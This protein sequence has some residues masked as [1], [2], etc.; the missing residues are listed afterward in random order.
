MVDASIHNLNN[1]KKYKVDIAQLQQQ[2]NQQQQLINEQA[3]Q[4]A[5]LQQQNQALEAKRVAEL[6]ELIGEYNEAQYSV[7]VH[8]VVRGTLM[9]VITELERQGRFNDSDYANLFEPILRSKEE[10]MMRHKAFDAPLLE[11][12][13]AM[14]AMKKC[15]NVLEFLQSSLAK[16]AKAKQHDYR[17]G[18]Y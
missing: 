6:N 3:Q 12:A 5:Q 4:I 13:D 16:A 1:C 7:G 10:N 17:P 15:P 14:H 11:S 9:D 2:N 18:A 8:S